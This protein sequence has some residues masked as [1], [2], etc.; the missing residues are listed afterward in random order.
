MRLSYLLLVLFATPALS[1]TAPVQKEFRDWVVTCDNLRSCI[2]EGANKD[3][4]TLIVRFGREA[5]PRGTVSMTIYGSPN[6]SDAMQ[7]QLDGKPLRVT[8]E[9]WYSDGTDDDQSF[10]TDNQ[11]EIH[12]LIDALRNGHALTSGEAKT[13]LD[14]LSAALLLIDDV[15]GRIDTDSAW[16]RRGDKLPD[17]VPAAPTAPVVVAHPYHGPA[18]T[19]TESA[20]VTAAALAQSKQDSNA[21][22]DLDASEDTPNTEADRLDEHDALVMVE[23]YR[24][25]Y[26]SG[27]RMFRVPIAQP[28]KVR[29]IVLPS[30]PG[31]Q[32]EDI[33]TDAEYD[34]AKGTLKH[35]AKGR[36]IGDCGESAQ[37]T[38]DGRDFVLAAMASEPRC[39]G[40]LLDF[41]V[42][43]RSR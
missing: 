35:F 39:P 5:G 2:A 15:Q 24:G 6:S 42:L 26:Q 18:L 14:G 17:A 41:P 23:C 10:E 13:S 31:Q 25:A 32:A 19:K 4:A 43:W 1:A 7:L 40:I 20:A 29:M 34:A 33:L 36:G 11:G 16:I 3:N 28:A 22:C 27:Y 21:D 12:T 9:D 37:W 30:I 38:F 8:K